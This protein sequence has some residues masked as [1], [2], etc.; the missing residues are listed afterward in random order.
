M[1]NGDTEEVDN[2][3]NSFSVTS[4]TSTEIKFALNFEKP[5]NV[6]QGY[7]PDVLIIQVFL[8]AF[9]DSNGKRLPPTVIKKEFLPL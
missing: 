7:Y 3:L 4:V 6:S 9:T 8:S 5:I 1:L 2:N